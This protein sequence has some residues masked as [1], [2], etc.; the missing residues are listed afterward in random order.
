M[1]PL[2]Y[3]KSLQ[4]GLTTSSHFSPPSYSPNCSPR[5]ISLKCKW[6]Y[7]TPLLKIRWPSIANRIKFQLLAMTFK[8]L[9]DLTLT[10]SVIQNK[11]LCKY[12]VFNLGCPCKYNQASLISHC[13]KG[14]GYLVFPTLRNRIFSTMRY[15]KHIGKQREIP[16][17][18][19]K[20]CQTLKPWRI[21]FRYIFFVRNMLWL[22]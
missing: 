19:S 22:I 4:T 5:V 1:S 10:T 6:S 2:D 20:C 3:Y 9:H 21:S 17:S 8:V 7:F 16:K 13:V 12:S 14:V 11:Q 18:T 15:F